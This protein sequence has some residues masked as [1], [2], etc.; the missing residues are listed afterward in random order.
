MLFSQFP[1][2]NEDS[3]FTTEEIKKLFCHS[4]PVRWR[5]NFVN[6]GQNIQEVSTEVL[7]TYMVQQEA[8]TDAHRKK[9]VRLIRRIKGLLSTRTK[10][11]NIRNMA[12]QLTRILTEIR[13]KVANS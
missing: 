9:S 1:S 10:V 4:I 8:Q 12:I 11:A 2:A 5:T 6:P 3:M 7:R 13:K